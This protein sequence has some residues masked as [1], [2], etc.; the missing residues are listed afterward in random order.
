MH[1]CFNL[2]ALR[3]I[4]AG[5]AFYVASVPFSI[6]ARMFAGG[7]VRAAGRQLN[8]ARVRQMAE[9]LL[10]PSSGHVIPPVHVSIE[11]A[12]Q[13]K[14]ACEAKS[15]GALSIEL[16]A[17]FSIID[18]R[19]RIAAVAFALDKRSDLSR[20]TLPVC[21]HVAVDNAAARAMF[22]TINRKAIRPPAR[23]FGEQT[24]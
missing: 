9:Y 16:N 7:Q 3:A 14:P 10:T 2:A 12:T 8:K 11:G 1:D 22:D 18:G 5:D 15:V 24:T 4:Q 17:E 21:F 19:H 13:F 23:K 6:A 20:E